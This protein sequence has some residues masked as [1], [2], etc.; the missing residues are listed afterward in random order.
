MN[1]SFW[2]RFTYNLQNMYFGVKIVTLGF[3]KWRICA[4]KARTQL[5]LH[6]TLLNM[7][8]GDS[9]SDAK[10]MGGEC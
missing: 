6:L 1:N 10:F 8:L 5:F 4:G 9:F 7:H 2:A 3:T